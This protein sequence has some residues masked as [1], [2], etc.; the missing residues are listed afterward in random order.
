MRCKADRVQL[1]GCV[2]MNQLLV[3]ELSKARYADYR[4]S[5]ATRHNPSPQFVWDDKADW[6]WL[7]A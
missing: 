5:K 2:P 3:S 7:P 1:D 6:V 4:T